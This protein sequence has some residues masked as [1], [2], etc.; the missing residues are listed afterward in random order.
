MYQVGCGQKQSSQFRILEPIFGHFATLDMC[1]G[2]LVDFKITLGWACTKSL[3]SKML[4]SFLPV[5]TFFI[6]VSPLYIY[7]GNT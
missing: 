5:D 6:V 2:C 7:C 1:A 4:T 3:K